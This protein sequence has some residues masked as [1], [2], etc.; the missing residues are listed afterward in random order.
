M[1]AVVE[2]DYLVVGAGAAGM[3]FTDALIDHADVSVVMVDRRHGVGGHWLDAYPF[4]RLH[5]ASAFYG[6]ASTLLGDGRIQTDGPEAGLHERATAPEIS[7]Y[8]GQVLR[9]R[10]LGSGRVSFYPSCDY[11]GDRQF[12]SRISGKRYEVAPE[13]RVVDARYLSPQIP[14]QTPAPFGTA[15][16]AHVVA[17]NDLV[18]LGGAS[19]QYVIAG[20]GKTATDAC[21]WLLDNGVDPDAICWVRPRDP[22]MLN[23]AVVQ[24]D[25]AVFI[26]MAAD[27]VEAATESTSPDDLFGRLE[28]AGVMLRVD[29]SVTPTMAKT[30]TLAQWELDRLRTIDQVVRL[31]HIKHVEPTRLV[32][33]HGEVTTAKDAVVVHCAAAGLQYPPLVPIWGPEAITLQPVRSG[34]PCFGAA[35]AGYVEATI[36]GDAEKNRLC[37]PSPLPNYP[38]D[39]ARMQVLGGRSAMSFASHPDIK[40]WADRVALNPARVPPE[41]AGSPEVTAAVDRF[42]RYVGP[43]LARMAE[44]AE[45]S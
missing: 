37:P 31:G 24:P 27:T 17:V 23:R 6:V 34:F 30:P 20:A 39:W 21:I 8:F 12:V 28:D 38:A 43:G 5:Q 9:R 3:A 4:V 33:D 2:A 14:A 26:G 36:D 22:W 40:A 45:M 11:L 44:L 29:R 13:T 1:A 32:L 15:D 16:G 25:P 7:A 35:L 18:R 41:L 10:M 42:R 19:S